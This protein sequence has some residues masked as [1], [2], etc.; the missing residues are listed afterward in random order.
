MSVLFLPLSEHFP[1]TSLPNILSLASTVAN[2]LSCN[3]PFPGYS[4]KIR[5]TGVSLGGVEKGG[6]GICVSSGKSFCCC[7]GGGNGGG[8]EYDEHL[9]VKYP[10]DSELNSNWLSSESSNTS[11]NISVSDD[12][13]FC[14]EHVSGVVRS[15]Y[16]S[17][18]DK[19][20]P[21]V[22]GPSDSSNCC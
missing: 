11:D 1:S 5:S 22:F 16:G 18:H 21:S 17:V 7:N 15:T 20:D 12:R 6:G 2:K 14:D 9:S 8:D 13:L 19:S 3:S 4:F 10:D